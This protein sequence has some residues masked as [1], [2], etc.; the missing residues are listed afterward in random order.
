MKWLKKLKI[1]T[2][3]LAGFISMMLCVS[4][5]GIVG[6]MAIRSIHR[7]LNQIFTV[8]LPIIDYLIESDRDL[9]QLLVAERSM[10]FSNTNSDIFKGLLN[11]YET[12]LNQAEERLDNFKKLASTSQ[13]VEL[14]KKFEETLKDW[15]T[16]SRKIVDGR[17]SD[18]REGRREA[19]DLSLGEA[20]AKFETM[21]D[22]IDQ[23][24]DI[25]LKLAEQNHSE[26][27]NVVKMAVILMLGVLSFSII[28]GLLFTWGS[29]REI[30]LPLRL[31]I[32]GLKDA[33][34]E[35]GEGARQVSAGSQQLAESASE[36]AASIEE[37]S[38]SLE[39]IASRTRQNAQNAGQ[40]RQ[41]MQQVEKIVEK[42][43][44]HMLQMGDAIHEITRTSEET[45]KIIKTIDEI[46][47]QTNLLAL[48]A[49]VEAARAG[50]AGAGFAVVADEVRSLAMRAA[51]AAQ[52]TSELIENII[53]SVQKGN[54]LTRNTQDA[55]HENIEIGG[56]VGN[57]VE[58]IA[59]SSDFQ[60]QGIEQ[61][62]TAVRE[63]DKVVQQV[64]SSAE[65]SSSAAEQMSAQAEEMNQIVQGLVDMVGDRTVHRL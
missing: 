3:L 49:A 18:T 44:R 32:G 11:E 25:N 21:R 13:E 50:E 6:Y 60:S 15:K 1:E 14:I 35:V 19:L 30:A 59:A 54:E 10:I 61:I 5:V 58:E 31:A 64:A 22:N 12:N 51:A 65:E 38:A 47:F 45:G 40:A 39:E 29:Y 4:T 7:E 57:L 16:V 52:N 20:K 43:D 9:Q 33:A 48:N 17:I 36:Q 46:A 34:L 53:K 62:N 23:L 41:M 26:A 56:K 24:T 2:K 27:E 42:V 55:F 8:R 63:M 37:T 28:V